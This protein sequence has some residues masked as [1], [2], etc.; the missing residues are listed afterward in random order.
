MACLVGFL[1]VTCTTHM[2]RLVTCLAVAVR[3]ILEQPCYAQ[4][5]N[6]EQR[7]SAEFAAQML[8]GVIATQPPAPDSMLAW[9]L[10]NPQAT[11]AERMAEHLRRGVDWDDLVRRSQLGQ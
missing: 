1:A 9:F 11:R 2:H 5:V 6:E 3:D 4:C 10:A 7:I 8:G